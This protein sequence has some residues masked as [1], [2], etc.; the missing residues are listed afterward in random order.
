MQTKHSTLN[1]TLALP[2]HFR[3]G[4]LLDFYRRDP[5]MLAERVEGNI[6]QK[7][8]VWEGHAACITLQLGEDQVNVELTIDGAVSGNTGSLASMVR[9]MLGLTQPV[10]AFEQ[11][12]RHHPQLGPLI[13]RN[14][15]LRVAVAATPFEAISWAITGQQISM[16]AAVSIRRRL[17]QAA[18]LR[19]SG[20][21]WCYPDAEH[22]DRLD[23]QRLGQAGLSRAKAA[24]LCELSRLVRGDRLPLDAWTESLPVDEL[25]MQLLG[26]RGI[27]PWTVDYALLRG[28][29]WLD[30][31]LHGDAAVRRHMQS[32]LARAE[33]ITEREAQRWL[34]EFSPWR[35]LVAAHLWAMQSAAGY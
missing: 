33:K 32:L 24:T 15:G 11:A 3:A 12:Y 22:L 1:C 34:A 35:A 20:G 21:L 14:P 19:H 7:G 29:G 17:I 13:A 18:G 5:L 25:R 9:R 4:E 23:V 2:A 8:L 28:F 30:G 6:L 26:V 16:A 31:S 10:E 27:G